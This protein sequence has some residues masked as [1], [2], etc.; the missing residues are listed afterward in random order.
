MPTANHHSRS[1]VVAMSVGLVLTVVAIVVPFLGSPAGQLISTHV[2][3]G[4]PS[5]TADEVAAATGMY[6]AWLTVAGVLGVAAWITSIVVVRT[7]E[8]WALWVAGT[9]FVVGAAIS[10]FDL[11]IRDTSGDTGLPALIG[12]LGVLPAAAGL[13][14]V[15]LLWK[16]LAA[17]RLAGSFAS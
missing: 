4:Y 5:Y 8:R 16:S 2:K 7:G 6:L 10:L 9:A 12:W 13:V 15:V 14:A 1:A 3:A 17:R 11:T